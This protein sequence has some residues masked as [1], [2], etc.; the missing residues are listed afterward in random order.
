MAY[1]LLG[2][3]RVNMPLLYGEGSK[4]FRRLQEELI[5]RSS[6]Q[7]IFHWTVTTDFH[8]AISSVLAQGPDNFAESAHVFASGEPPDAPYALTNIGLEIRARSTKLWDSKWGGHVYV[9]KLNC[10]HYQTEAGEAFS[11][12]VPLVMAVTHKGPPSSNSYSGSA[13]RER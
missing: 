11:R 8:N 12:L 4:A 3:L 13:R 2:I 5:R 9:I 6:D 7:S 1:C 10:F